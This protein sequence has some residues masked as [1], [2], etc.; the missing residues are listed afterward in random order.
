[1]TLS[2]DAALRAAEEAEEMA[3]KATP[4]PWTRFCRQVIRVDL[5]VRH[6]EQ[7]CIFEDMDADVPDL[8]FCAHARAAVP[9]LARYV[10][11]LV[12]EV[13]RLRSDPSYLRPDR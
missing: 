4:G 13:E 2:L 9:Q 11:E 1:M 12:G 10:V 5:E 3:E 7:L 8:D 6:E